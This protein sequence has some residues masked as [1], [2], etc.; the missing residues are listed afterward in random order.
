M[1]R[2][3]RV[4]AGL[5]FL[6][7]WLVILASV[8]VVGC[9]TGF[10]DGQ[11]H[12]KPSSSTATAPCLLSSAQTPLRERASL[13]TYAGR[14]FLVDNVHL[15]WDIRLAEGTAIYPIGC[16]V[17]RIARSAQGYGTL[18]VVI[19]HQLAE[20]MI[21]LNGLGTPV[22]V[23]R[24]LSIY[25]HIRGT[26]ER[27]G[28]GTTVRVGQAVSTDMVLGYIEHASLNGDGAEHLHLGVRLQSATFAQQADPSAWFR[29]YDG[30]P[31][32]RRWFTNPRTFL[33]M[34]DEDVGS[35]S[36]ERDGRDA[37]VV[38]MDQPPL[39]RMPPPP[40]MP[41]P[42]PP[43]AQDAGMVLPPPPPPPPPMMMQDV[44][45][46][47]PPPPVTTD[48]PRPLPERYRYAFRVRSAVRV[49]PPYYLRDQWWRIILCENTGREEPFVTSD[50]FAQCDAERLPFFDGSVFAPDHLDWG[51]RGQIATVGNSPRR[52]TYTEG[53]EW[54]ITRL[55]DQRVLYEG[56]SSGLR[57]GAVGSQDRLVFPD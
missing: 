18:A 42:P 35:A 33:A 23:D 4:W 44:G 55:R 5:A 1:A 20:P 41:S 30:T 19:E 57:C 31:S 8:G 27:G 6:W 29:G 36:V 26:R 50:G 15:G 37:G 54:R 25:G 28:R 10:V 11:E 24:F 51:D 12:E 52:C 22:S 39:P 45:I 2:W 17:V 13:M 40:P 43:M 16:G 14:E 47:L 49:T 32:Q 53:A 3:M 9:A 56:P 48:V 38:Q 21:V 7:F 46:A 34:L